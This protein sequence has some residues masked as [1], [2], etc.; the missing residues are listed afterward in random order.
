MEYCPKCLY[1]LA[2]RAQVRP[3]ICVYQTLLNSHWTFSVKTL[4]STLRL[5]SGKCP[6]VY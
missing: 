6:S 4:Q 3:I 1:S 5:C 2:L